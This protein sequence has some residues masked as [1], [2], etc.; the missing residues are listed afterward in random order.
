MKSV[1]VLTV[2]YRRPVKMVKKPSYNHT[3]PGPSTPTGKYNF[4]QKGGNGGTL[5]ANVLVFFIH[6]LH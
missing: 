6:L 1:L 2:L 3:S 5:P 4:K